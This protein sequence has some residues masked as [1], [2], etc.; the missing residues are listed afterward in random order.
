MKESNT[1]YG[2]SSSTLK[3]KRRRKP[4]QYFTSYMSFG[5]GMTVWLS[6]L[7]VLYLIVLLYFSAVLRHSSQDVQ[8]SGEQNRW[9]ETTDRNKEV[10]SQQKQLL[11]EKMK[12][13]FDKIRQ[14]VASNQFIQQAQ[15][16]IELLRKAR[17]V[18]STDSTNDI[19]VS[20]RDAIKN[21]KT[22][23]GFIVLGMH[24]SG[25]SVL[26]GLLVTGLGYNAGAPLIGEAFDNEKG[27]FE[28]IP[29]VLQNDEFLYAQ[30]IDWSYD[31]VRYNYMKGLALANANL[32]SGSPKFEEGRKA[33]AFLNNP[34]S[35]PWLQKDPRMCITLKTWLPLLSAEPAVVWTYR[36]PMEVSHSLISREKSFTLDHALR[37]WIV[38][39]MRALQNSLGLCRVYTSNE[40][41]F[42]NPMQE[43]QRISD[44]L[45]SKCNV[46][47]PPTV[48]TIEQVNKFVD[49]TLQHNSKSKFNDGPIIATHGTDC[50]VHELV[51]TTKKTDPKYEIEVTFYRI[52]MKIYCDMKSGKAYEIAY[53]WPEW[54]P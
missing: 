53:D 7:I 36:H 23:N 8:T 42:K 12:P 22:R 11:V 45:T 2:G 17:I 5:F 34:Q 46:P 26:S 35:V 24:R 31:V 50:D 20:S 43:V 49:T 10:L 33:L 37:L 28:L 39:N 3:S 27:F 15:K 13:F 30:E 21:S 48:L 6:I 16:E 51:T 25:T 40:A 1:P 29:V 19:M 14:N 32:N 18:N 47:K 9:G 41:I 38:Y 54:P 44:E 4:D 52:A